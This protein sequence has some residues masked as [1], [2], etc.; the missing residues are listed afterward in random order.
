VG[1]QL[2]IFG[3]VFTHAIDDKGRVQ[4]PIS[5][6]EAVHPKERGSF[7]LT[8]GL[9]ECIFAYTKSRFESLLRNFEQNTNEWENGDVRRVHLLFFMNQR[10]VELDSQ[11]RVLV[12]EALRQYADLERQAVIVGAGN[13]VE[14]WNPSR[15]AEFVAQSKPVFEKAAGLVFGRPKFTP[16]TD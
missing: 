15:F 13:R 11:S 7:Y 14:I 12:P 2:E 5:L 3:G 1:N 4:F 6:L 8:A 10:M 9:G 16:G